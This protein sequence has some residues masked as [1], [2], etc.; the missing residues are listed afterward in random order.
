MAFNCDAKGTTM[1]RLFAVIFVVVL[2]AVLIIK[3][4]VK[5]WR[6]TFQ[7]VV[8]IGVLIFVGWIMTAE[9]LIVV[10]R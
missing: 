10:A 6:R 7:L 5:T 1:L 8:L 9:H 2:A 3:D 4:P